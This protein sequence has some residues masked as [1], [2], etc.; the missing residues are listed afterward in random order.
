VIDAKDLVAAAD[1]EKNKKASRVN[2]TDQRTKK[3]ME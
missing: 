2:R 1:N 3:R